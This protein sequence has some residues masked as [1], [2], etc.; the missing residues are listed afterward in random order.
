MYDFTEVPTDY[1]EKRRE[2]LKI[3]IEKLKVAHATETDP[4]LL[5]NQINGLFNLQNELTDI[6]KELLGRGVPAVKS[7]PD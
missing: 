4:Q 5:Q 3:V 6:E 2:S 7:S 1:L